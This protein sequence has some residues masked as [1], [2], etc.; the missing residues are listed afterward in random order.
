MKKILL[1]PAFVLALIASGYAQKNHP[2]TVALDTLTK[3]EQLPVVYH[4]AFSPG[5]KLTYRVRY[6]FLDAGEATIEVKPS[7][8]TFSGRKVHHVVGIG[9]TISA[10]NWFYKVHDV[11]ESYID[12]QGVFPWQFERDVNEG[13]YSFQ[14]NYRFYQEKNAVKTHKDQTFA[15]PSGVQDMISAFYYART[16]DFSNATPGQIF[17]VKSFVDEEIFDL[18]VRYLGRE[19]VRTKLGTF[20]CL[21]FVPH[22]QEGRVFKK[23]ESV[24]IWVS[25]DAN[26]IP[27]MAKADILIG[28]IKMELTDY[29]GISNPL[30]QLR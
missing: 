26:K 17:T 8:R 19:T 7:N 10:F 9:R 27:I 15:T 18:Q 28:S 14:Q 24:V 30:A 4:N 1:L 23:D 2:P 13:S 6:G 29:Q 12:A 21:K 3:V 20:R 25:D 11:Y 5:E 22:V 16:F